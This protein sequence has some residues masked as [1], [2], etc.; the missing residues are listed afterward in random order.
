MCQRFR[1]RVGQ[2]SSRYIYTLFFL[3]AGFLVLIV[4][5]NNVAAHAI[6]G[7]PAP[8][9][10][11]SLRGE[12]EGEAHVL[13]RL[14][15]SAELAGEIQTSRTEIFSRYPEAEKS[16]SN[17]YF[18]YMMCV[19]IMDDKE[20]STREKLDELIRVRNAFREPEM[21]ETAPA[22][23]VPAGVIAFTLMDDETTFL[24][25]GRHWFT[26]EHRTAGGKAGCIRV[27]VD[28]APNAQCVG[29]IIE[30]QETG[31]SCGIIYLGTK[32]EGA[33]AN[34]ALRCE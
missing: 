4:A 14:I 20:L 8:V 24:L 19:T 9:A 17:S 5:S 28:G 30:V 11:D 7:D 3:G 13:S 10:D 22:Q 29:N 1:I 27:V 21:T 6:C 2:H 16:R 12:I 31:M 34:F 32:D 18:E 33:T 15:G 25:D 23:N 26:Y